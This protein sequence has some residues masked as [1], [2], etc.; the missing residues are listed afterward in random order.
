MTAE[1]Y[2]ATFQYS[3]DPKHAWDFTW[4]WQ[5][6]IKNYDEAVK[7]KVPPQVKSQV[8]TMLGRPPRQLLQ[9]QDIK[10]RQTRQHPTAVDQCITGH[11]DVPV[12]I[13]TGVGDPDSG[14]A[15]GREWD[16]SPDRHARR[17]ISREGR[18]VVRNRCRHE[19]PAVGKN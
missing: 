7:A 15:A 2:V 5:G 4:Y 12:E 11:E 16:R 6:V 18:K 13:L 8:K 3:A 17:R 19:D 10:A 14:R 9:W 1:D